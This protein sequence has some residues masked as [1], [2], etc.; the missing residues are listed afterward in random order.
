MSRIYG[1]GLNSRRLTTTL[2][3][4]KN[5][6]AGDPPNDI[7][8]CPVC[9][10]E[11]VHPLAVEV[12]TGRCH[13]KVDASGLHLHYGETAETFEAKQNRGIIISIEYHCESGHHGK[14]RF[15]FHKGNTFVE[16]ESLPADP[17]F[18]TLWRT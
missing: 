12:S 2:K 9:G 1:S 10:C 18:V 15:M 5:Y 3:I 11:F 4:I 17:N 14:I 6:M 13:L 8:V 7:L 16:H